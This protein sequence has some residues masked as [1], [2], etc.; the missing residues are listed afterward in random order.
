MI[1]STKKPTNVF[2]HANWQMY[3]QS[4]EVLQRIM[5]TISVIKRTSPKSNIV[6]VGGI[7]QWEEDLP[8]IIL[9][10]NIKL[11]KEVYWEPNGDSLIVNKRLDN[12]LKS[13]ANSAGA[14]FVSAKDILCTNGECKAVLSTDKGYKLT[15]WDY[16]HLTDE[17]SALVARRIIEN[18]EAKDKKF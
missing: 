18:L 9:D 3:A 7:P 4:A 10:K 6:I 12:Y 11:D 1:I 5:S 17:G 13:S 16:G 2:M 14:Y 8:S 15:T